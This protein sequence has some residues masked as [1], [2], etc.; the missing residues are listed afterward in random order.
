[1]IREASK[2]RM[3]WDKIRAAEEKRIRDHY[4]IETQVALPQALAAAEA[5]KAFAKKGSS[6]TTASPHP[7]AP[8]PPRLLAPRPAQAK[9]PLWKTNRPKL[10]ETESIS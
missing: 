1:M 3:Y 9:D 4:R 2:E 7:Q 5:R 8:S 10:S 6:R